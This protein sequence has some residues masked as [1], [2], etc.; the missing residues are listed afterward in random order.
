MALST[1]PQGKLLDYEQYIDHQLGR[2]RA[3]IK[4]TDVLTSSLILAAAAL[5]VLFLEV[6]LDH[7]IGL[8]LWLRQAILFL[9]LAG[10]TAF[11]VLRIVLPLVSNVNGFYA[12]RTIE[13]TDPAFKN[14]LISYLDLKRRRNEISR[15]A[16]AAIEA[17]AVNDLTQVQVETVVN[18]RRLTQM[19]Y[20]LSAVVVVFCMYAALTPK[21]IL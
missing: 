18:Q 5:L 2:T 13:E 1:Q 15:A 17:K 21:S 6:V 19:A 10:G 16:M 11:V 8:P 4:I 14:S 20:V 12:A 3:R 9:G 7:T